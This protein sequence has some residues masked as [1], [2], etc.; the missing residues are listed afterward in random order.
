M[1]D[2]F[3]D[4]RNVMLQENLGLL[5]VANTD[6]GV[7]NEYS[8]AFIMCFTICDER[9]KIVHL[10]RTL[11]ALCSNN[12]LRNVDIALAAKSL[13]D[14]NGMII[15]AHLN[16][17]EQLKMRMIIAEESLNAI[18]R[19]K[20]RRKLTYLNDE[21]KQRHADRC[22]EIL[23]SVDNIYRK[24]DLYGLDMFFCIVDVPLELEELI[25]AEN[26][27]KNGIKI[28]YQRESPENTKHCPVVPRL[29]DIFTEKYH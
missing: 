7:E 2:A 28:F 29:Y 3:S 27:P 12:E 24:S 17:I 22:V 19:T 18:K 13:F 16:S 8:V 5:R 10:S 25:G 1:L 20:L 11:N 4:A 6:A 15:D 21:I 26:F 23:R 9:T 14:G